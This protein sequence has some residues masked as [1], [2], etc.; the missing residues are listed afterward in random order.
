MLFFN[1]VVIMF[2]GLKVIVISFIFKFHILNNILLY[3]FSIQFFI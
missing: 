3:S 2:L 1:L